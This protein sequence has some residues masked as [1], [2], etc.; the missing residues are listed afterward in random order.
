MIE[1]QR[2]LRLSINVSSSALHFMVTRGTKM[3]DNIKNTMFTRM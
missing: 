1:Y 2:F 3:P